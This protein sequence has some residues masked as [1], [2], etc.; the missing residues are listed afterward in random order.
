MPY[1]A[2][3]RAATAAKKAKQ[4]RNI[5][6]AQA[7]NAE[8]VQKRPTIQ[9]LSHESMKKSAAG[10]AQ[11]LMRKTEQEDFPSRINLCRPEFKLEDGGFY[12]GFMFQS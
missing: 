6:K 10:S 4:A 1:L 2:A 12:N 5:A 3:A 9:P 8:R 11:E 7:R